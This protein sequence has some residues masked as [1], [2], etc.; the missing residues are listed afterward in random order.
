MD[1][2]YADDVILRE[3]AASR[4]RVFAEDVRIPRRFR[5]DWRQQLGN[6][7]PRDGLEWPKEV[8]EMASRALWPEYA[9]GTANAACLLV[10]HRPG[11]EREVESEE[12]L[13][14]VLFIQ[15]RFPVLGGIAHAHN[16][17]FPVNYLTTKPTW[18]NI[19]KYLKPAFA[20]L[21]NT[22][23]QLMTCNINT[24]HGR[25]GE[26]DRAG[27][28]LGLSILDHITALCQPN[29]I[30][31]CG[32]NVHHAARSWR[33]PQVVRIERIAHP[34]VWHRTSMALPNGN[35]TYKIVRSSL[36]QD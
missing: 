34:S 13:D 2:L 14:R 11:L 24:D 15:P 29:L 3:K 8:R 9:F 25:T 18:K 31:L 28:I 26:V 1:C 20:G 27:N 35:E 23:S 36:F 7:D 30:L 6:R 32:R 12:D 33:P 22:W 16:A 4:Y 17:L 10:M 19:H 5:P 21:R